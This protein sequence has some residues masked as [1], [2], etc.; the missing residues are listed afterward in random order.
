MAPQ[1][2]RRTWMNDAAVGG[3]G[4]WRGWKGGGAGRALDPCS[5]RP[6]IPAARARVLWP[7]LL[8]ADHGHAPSFFFSLFS[9]LISPA[10]DGVQ[11]KAPK[12][13]ASFDTVAAKRPGGEGVS[14]VKQHLKFAVR[15]RRPSIL[16]LWFFPSAFLFPS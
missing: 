11:Q 16:T 15:L 14:Y 13:K 3:G 8:P 2:N 4:E 10:A 5:R 7:V 9:F 6:P 1:N 12:V